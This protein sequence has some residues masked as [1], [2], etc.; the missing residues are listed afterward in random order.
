M[1]DKLQKKTGKSVAF[2]FKFNEVINAAE[3]ALEK[4]KC[5]PAKY[6]SLK[7]KIENIYEDLHKPNEG[8][9]NLLKPADMKKYINL[10]KKYINKFYL[11]WE[12][13]ESMIKVSW[14]VR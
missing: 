4:S 2:R 8:V 12:I 11:N 7:Y 3:A 10:M 5:S 13:F 14:K 1:S 6:L 9:A